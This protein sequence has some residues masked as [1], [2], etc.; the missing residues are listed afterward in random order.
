MDDRCDAQGLSLCL[1]CM[2]PSFLPT[3]RRTEGRGAFEDP[4]FRDFLGD[5]NA[6]LSWVPMLIPLFI[7]IPFHQETERDTQRW[8]GSIVSKEWHAMGARETSSNPFFFN[9][10]ERIHLFFRTSKRISRRFPSDFYSCCTKAGS[11]TPPLSKG[12]ILICSE[13]KG[14]WF[15]SYVGSETVEIRWMQ[16]FPFDRISSIFF[17]ID[18]FPSPVLGLGRHELYPTY[19]ILQDR[20]MTSFSTA[21]TKKWR[22]S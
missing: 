5:R 10:R 12:S 13:R 6:P 9:E 20:N 16:A 2:D 11:M 17:C 1:S 8:N 18:P 22:G 19:M 4:D 15:L 21:V 7:R 14:G 3:E